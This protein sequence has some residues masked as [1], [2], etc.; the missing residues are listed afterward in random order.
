MALMRTGRKMMMG[1]PPDKT[2]D[3]GPMKVL[4]AAQAARN[5][6]KNKWWF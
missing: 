5:A 3:V 4:S 1:D 6:C 2:R